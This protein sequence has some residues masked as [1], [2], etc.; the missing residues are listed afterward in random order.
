MAV[1][2]MCPYCRSGI[3]NGGPLVTCSRCGTTHHFSCWKLDNH[4]SVFGCCGE[5]TSGNT[6][7][8]MF[9]LPPAIILLG[10]L[11]QQLTAVISFLLLP[12][13]L[14]SISSVLIHSYRLIR[15]AIEGISGSD[16]WQ[17]IFFHLSLN[18]SSILFF[19]YRIPE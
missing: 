9:L 6:D 19:I 18:L 7:F 10:S 8:P 12:A 3:E 5:R 17:R 1:A 13:F 4:C 2:L 11:S 15:F 14:Y 16:S